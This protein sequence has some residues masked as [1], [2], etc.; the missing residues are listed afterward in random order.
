MKC[1]H[2]NII[3]LVIVEMCFFYHFSIPH[4]FFLIFSASA[5][6]FSLASFLFRV[7]FVFILFN[8]FFFFHSRARHPL[9]YVPR[10]YFCCFRLSMGFWWVRLFISFTHTHT[11]ASAPPAQHFYRVANKQSLFKVE[12]G[13]FFGYL[14]LGVYKR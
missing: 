3:V 11:R 14:L 10:T 13:I 12:H 9:S 5:S 2:M 4:F 7:C 6:T 1:F 8:S